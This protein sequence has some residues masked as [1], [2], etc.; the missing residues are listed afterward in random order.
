[1]I[2]SEVAD[3]LCAKAGKSDYGAITAVL[4]YYGVA[5]KLFTVSAGNFLPA[6]KVNSTVV[7]IRL[8]KTKPYS[9]KDDKTLF[10]TIKGAFEQRRKTLPNALSA[11]FSELDKD[12]ITNAI[13]EC[14]HNPDIRGEK[15]SIEQFVTLA[16]KL[17]ELIKEK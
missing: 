5:E 2:Q 11:C 13:V 9:P 7:R 3:R 14:G 8:H 1:M 15:L 12:E 10:R 17:Y 4:A 6:P 16:D